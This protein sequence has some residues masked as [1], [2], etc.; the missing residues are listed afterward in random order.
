MNA[1]T[2]A[3][4]AAL[5]WGMVP[6]IEKAGLGSVQPVVGVFFRSLG[7]VLGLL[8]M[9]FFMIEPAQFRAINVRSMLLL[10]AGG[11]LASFVGQLTFYHALKLG[12]ISKVVPISAS[13]PLVTFIIGVLIF[14]EN[15]S[16][17]RCL[18]VLSIIAGIWA[19]RIG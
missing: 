17:L 9:G 2:W 16:L 5:I 19:I 10:M 4:G 7:V 12:E 8:I 11:F 14:R 3:I 13:Y 15:L 18:G 1:Y 6:I